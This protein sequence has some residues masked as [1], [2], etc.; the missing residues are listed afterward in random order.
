MTAS[1]SGVPQ[2]ERALFESFYATHFGAKPETWAQT[3]A[4]FPGCTAPKGREEHYYIT[5][6]QSHWLAWQARA[7][8]QSP[9]GQASADGA[10]SAEAGGDYMGT[11]NAA[12]YMNLVLDLHRVLDGG[13]PLNGFKI[14]DEVAAA[15]ASAPTSTSAPEVAA[16]AGEKNQCDGC[17]AGWPVDGAGLHRKNGRAEMVCQA[18][19]YP[20]PATEPPAAQAASED[21]T[22]LLKDIAVYGANMMWHLKPDTAAGRLYARIEQSLS[23]AKKGSK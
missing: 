15:L 1:S 2:S 10:R 23:N 3:A 4:K 17:A 6:A 19:R 22:A 8:L 9:A 13:T 14:V 21:N 11:K 5:A 12:R 18:Y 20:A 7:A 16:P